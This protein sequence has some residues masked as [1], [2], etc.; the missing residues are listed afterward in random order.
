M[1]EH[2]TIIPGAQVLFAFLLTV[3]FASRFADVDGLARIV[4]TVSLVAVSASTFL[5]LAPAAY[6]R[7]AEDV[8]RGERIRFGVRMTL[9]GLTLLAVSITCAIFVV[10]RFVLGTPAGLVL[11]GLMAGFALTLWYVYPRRAA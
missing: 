11:A 9:A 6:H 5:F 10:V 4:F 7:L 2:R 1:E 8:S 3:P